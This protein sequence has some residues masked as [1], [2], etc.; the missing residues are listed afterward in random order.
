MSARFSALV[1]KLTP[2]HSVPAKLLQRE[3]NK[4][5]LVA[6]GARQFD[7]AWPTLRQLQGALALATEKARAFAD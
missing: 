4:L 1:V 5:P 3:I 7:R 6:I 2:L